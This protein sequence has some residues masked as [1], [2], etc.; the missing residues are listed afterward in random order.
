MHA[1]FILLSQEV[2]DTGLSSVCISSAE[3]LIQHIVRNKL[4]PPHYREEDRHVTFATHR[5]LNMLTVC[6]SIQKLV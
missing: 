4:H 6:L 3:I 1:L 5:V 2:I